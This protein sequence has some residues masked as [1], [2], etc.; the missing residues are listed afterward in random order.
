MNDVL[1]SKVVRY[2]MI[3]FQRF[4]KEG[5]HLSQSYSPL[6]LSDG[7]EL[8]LNVHRELTQF[9]YAI[10]LCIVTP[11]HKPYFVQSYPFWEH[12][13]DEDLEFNPLP[14]DSQDMIHQIITSMTRLLQHLP[15][16]QCESCASLLTPFEN[17]YCMECES[18][19]KQIL[20][21]WCK[22]HASCFPVKK[23]NCGH[24]IHTVCY[25]NYGCCFCK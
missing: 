22:D 23:L 17:E 14:S 11:G 1:R 18:T 9:Y 19:R 8:K 4:I 15:F 5:R 21:G 25:E 7:F 12:G 24:E 2:I 13:M 16:V 3:I 20:C 10:H 6:F